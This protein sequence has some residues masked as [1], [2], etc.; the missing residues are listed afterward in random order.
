EKM[1][2]SILPVMGYN[3]RSLH[4]SPIEL[5]LLALNTIR[6]FLSQVQGV[7]EVRIIGGKTKEFWVQLDQ[8]KMSRTSTNPLLVNDALGQTNFIR[9]NG[10]VSDFNFL[11]LSV[12]D[13]TVKTLD[14]LR[15]TVIK[16]DGKRI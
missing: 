2:P 3:L 8:E 11:Y 7:S 1:N 13:A 4:L 6:P 15:N 12:T 14:D 9:S 10:N 5:K 16:N